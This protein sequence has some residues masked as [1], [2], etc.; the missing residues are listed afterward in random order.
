M[1]M[2]TTTTIPFQTKHSYLTNFLFSSSSSTNLKRFIKPSRFF[3]RQSNNFV[4]RP[5]LAVKACAINVEEKNVAGK[6]EQWEK[7]SAVL[8][9]MDGVLCNSEEPSRRAGVDL[10]AE[11]GV[12]VTVDDFVPFMGTGEANFLGGVASV[13]GVEGFNTEAAKKRFFEIYLDKYAKPDSG[14]GF[15]GAL[16][17]ISQCKSKGLKVAVA[18]SADRIKVDANL[19]AA[20]LPLSMFDAIVSADAFENLK[21][22][23]DIFLAA[24]RILNVPP[25][26]CIVIED[27]LAGVQAANAAQMRCIAVRTTLSD[28]ALESAG[29]NFIR[30]DIGSVSLDDI[31]NGASVGYNKR[32]QGSETPNDFPQSSSDVLG[33]KID[34]VGRTTSGTD[35]EILST[36]GLQ[37]SR[38]DILRF[39]SLGIAIS[40]LVFTLNNWKAM[41]YTSP[42]AV[43]NLLFGVTQP[44]MDYKAGNTRSDRIPQFV[45]Y[46]ADLES[47]E[48]AQLV[49]EFPSKLDWLNTAPLQFGRDLK[50]KV[51]LLDFWTYCCIN[52]M[53][54]LPDLDALEKKYKDMPFVVVGVHSAKF[55]NEKDSEAIRNAVLRYDVTHPVVNDGDMYFWRKLGI[56]SWPTFAIIGPNDFVLFLFDKDLDDF[57]AAALLFY[58]KQNMLDNTPI[59]LNLEKDNDPRLVTSPL[60]FPG[61]LAIDV[62][63]NRLFISDSNHNRIVVTSLDGNFIVQIGSSGEEGLQDGSFD[64]ATFNRPQGLA[65]NAKKN[66][67]YVADTENHALREIDFANEK[68][69]TLAGNGTKGSDY[70]GG[71]KGNTQLLNSPWDVCFHPFE[72]KIYVAMAGQHQ[73]WEH[74]I[75]S[76]ITRA[77]SGDGYERNLNGSS[78]TSTSFAQPSGLSL[79]QDLTEIYVAD[80]ESS[81]IRVVD[82]K[83]GGSRLLA[84]GDPIFSDNLFKFGDQDGI[85]SEVLL[86]H[87]LGVVCGKDGIIYITDSY[88]HKI[89]KL[90]PTSKRVST[91]AGTGKAG[92]RDGI[93]IT[94]QL[95]EPSGI[96]EG[97]NG[98]L[99][100]ADTN[101][102]LIRYLDLN[103]NEL[104]TL[105][106]KG[107]QP[108]KP[109][110]RS[111][112][113]LRRRP[114]AD[115][116]PITIDAISSEE[117]NL[118]IEISLPNEY[119]FS[120]EARSRFSVDIEPEDTVNIDPLDGFLSPEG[121]ATLHF[122]RSS[123]SASI[124][125]INCK[126]YYCKEDEVCLYKSLLFEVP[127]REGVFDTAKA[128]VTLAHLVKPKSSTSSLLQPIAP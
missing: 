3:H 25:S 90:D 46:I 35:E 100:I 94:A 39:G 82:L 43:W 60:K 127:F 96:V 31:L 86:Q 1:A 119:H 103:T 74:N 51:V 115:T 84:G 126:I 73:I 123:N 23:P 97:S 89:K 120:K 121:S 113:R 49:P 34:G 33:G 13:K 98:R 111:F 17:L 29:P 79:S 32:M 8:F 47:R 70:T 67:L 28:E 104:Y 93:S 68:V 65:Y 109:K 59:T 21:P 40:C 112:K 30:D 54:V 101:N 63:N 27:A 124:G 99:F 58:G 6:S 75:L 72:E 9:D 95:S 50:G 26:E 66:I 18:S 37:G 62:L 81:S 69:R 36:G 24:S 107:V 102:S 61:K 19:A 15:P 42:Q 41:Q 116:V 45:K 7:V 105:E 4:S 125:R 55:D 80:S 92:F 57:V 22:A 64:E 88:N 78:S 87:P 53:H 110:S 16:E 91:V 108:P 114:T 12:Q 106:L 122:K 128:D 2:A 76:G 71:G 10:F 118:S 44:S 77:F 56:N 14:I 5:R 117:G 85:G 48:N 38:R 20:G 83:T 52:C 11:I